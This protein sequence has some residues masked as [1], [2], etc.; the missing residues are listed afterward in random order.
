ML[1]RPVADGEFAELIRGDVGGWLHLDPEAIGVLREAHER[2]AR[3][4][5]LSNAPH[6]LA[7]VVETLPEL[8]FFDAYVFSAR[9]GAAKP[10]PAAF[11]AALDVMGAPADEVVFID[12]REANVAGARAVGID[13]RRYTNADVLRADLLA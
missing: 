7:D 5:L 9:I 6:E 12:D 2:G 10:D 8:G 3:L 11:Q 1:D 13:A 4:T